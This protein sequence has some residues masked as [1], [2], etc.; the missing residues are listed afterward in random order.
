MPVSSA[1][2]LARVLVDDFRRDPV[3]PIVPGE[4]NRHEF[5]Y[6]FFYFGS[7]VRVKNSVWPILH[8]TILIL[9]LE[10]PL[11]PVLYLV[12]ALLNQGQPLPAGMAGVMLIIV[13]LENLT[14]PFQLCRVY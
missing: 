9:H 13:A 10:F 4:Q 2:F 3:V 6:G 12:Y 5:D 8:V 7:I 1:L 14:L 11:R